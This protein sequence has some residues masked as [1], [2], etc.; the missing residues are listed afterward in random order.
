MASELTSSSCEA[1]DQPE[2]RRCQRLAKW[3]QSR[4][5]V[6]ARHGRGQDGKVN[7]TF[8][9]GRTYKSLLDTVI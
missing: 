7:T 1:Q 9:S 2:K 8:A 6:K 5:K 3:Q 4:E